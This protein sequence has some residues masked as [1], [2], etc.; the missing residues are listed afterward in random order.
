MTNRR[1][2]LTGLASALS[3][4]GDARA[5][6]ETTGKKKHRKKGSGGSKVTP[7]PRPN[8]VLVIADDMRRGD[9][10]ALPQ[11]RQRLSDCRWFDNFI[12]NNPV[13]TPSRVTLLT[14]QY[15]HNHGVIRNAGDDS[16]A[17]YAAYVSEDL[18]RVALAPVMQKAGYATAM[19]GK[20]LNGYETSMAPARGWT[21][22]VGRESMSYTDYSLR[23]D[24][25]ELEFSGQKNYLTDVL[26]DY[27]CEFVRGVP[28][29]SPLY[30]YLGMAAPHPPSDPAKR[31]RNLY[32]DAAVPRT[33]AFNDAEVSDKPEKIARNPLLTGEQIAQLDLLQRKRLQ[34]M[35][36][37]DEGIVKVLDTLRE[38]G[39]L[40]NTHVIIMSDN[41]LLMGEHRV[42]AN[43][44]LPYDPAI[45]I[46]M[47]AWG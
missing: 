1:A 13:C 7:D 15:A 17:G 31:H 12:I 36:A 8:I 25:E 10:Q 18:D 38:T 26:A 21:R 24:D 19:I 27:A 39:R 44:G 41:G 16:E 47:L 42:F 40:D 30:L 33:E 5:Q 46:P 23:V 3:A 28:V 29:E 35:A 37:L 4:S 20:F 22:W 9:W 14:G 32:P 45:R 34:T 11:T 2:L 6:I 43:K